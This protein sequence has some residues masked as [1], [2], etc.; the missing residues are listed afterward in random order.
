MGL[1]KRLVWPQEF[2]TLAADR[3]KKGFNV[4]QIVAGLYPDMPPFDPRGA[5]EAGLPWEG[6]AAGPSATPTFTRIRP[7]YFDAADLRLRYLVDQGISPC[8]VGAWGYF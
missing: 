2:K 6:A 4:V 7:E 3:R 8:I 1:S 5:N